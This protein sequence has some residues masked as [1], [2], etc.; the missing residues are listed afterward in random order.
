[1]SAQTDRKRCEVAEGSVKFKNVIEEQENRRTRKEI[2]AVNKKTN[3]D[4]S[5]SGV[6][7]SSQ[8]AYLKP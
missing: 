4:S 8:A 2:L 7:N 1:V 3:N 5:P 6:M